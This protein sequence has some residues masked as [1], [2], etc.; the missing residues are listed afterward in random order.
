MWFIRRRMTISYIQDQKN[1]VSEDHVET[2]RILWT[3]YDKSMN[4][5]IYFEKGGGKKGKETEVEGK[6][7]SLTE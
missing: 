6:K 4:I 2:R 5:M 3:H 1:T 7:P